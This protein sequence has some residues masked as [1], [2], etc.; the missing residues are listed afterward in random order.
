MSDLFG[1]PFFGAPWALD[2]TAFDSLAALLRSS[3]ELTPERIGALMGRAGRPTHG[4]FC[5][6]SGNTYWADAAGGYRAASGATATKRGAHVALINVSGLLLHRVGGFG[7]WLTSTDQIASLVKAAAADSNTRG[8]VLDVDSNGGS[9]LGLQEAAAAIRAAARRKP[10]VASINASGL[11]AAYWLAANAGRVIATPSAQVGSVGVIGE[12][13][14]ASGQLERDGIKVTLLTF[15]ENKAA[16][17]PSQ[18][19]SDAG[20]QALQSRVDDYGRQFLAD[21]AAGRRVTVETVRGRF[22]GGLSFGAGEA[23]A[24]GMVDEI[25]EFGVAL[26]HAVSGEPLG[27][28]AG[29]PGPAIN[30]RSDADP[31]RAEREAALIRARIA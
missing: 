19:L 1:V 10:V 21:V 6:D 12:H 4:Y 17:H 24:R 2:R 14:D 18:P 31:G 30:A 15:G 3:K 16:G 29:D 20:R 26:R 27:P 11:S 5:L 22:G 9:V 25:G 13:I 28:L 7:A 8:V 23:R